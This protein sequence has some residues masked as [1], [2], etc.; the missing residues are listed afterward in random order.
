MSDWIMLL[1]SQVVTRI[2]NE[3]SQK[4]KTAYSMTDKNFSTE[5]T[6]IATTTFPHVFVNFLPGVETGIDLERNE[7]NGGLFTWQ[8]EV[9]DKSLSKAREVMKEIVRIMRMLHFSIP[10][11]PSMTNTEDTYTFTARF[12]RAIDVN[13]TL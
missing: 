10:S 4:I 1:P 2:K 11:M 3:F 12:R 6:S 13:D 9:T 5:A 7:I 8:I